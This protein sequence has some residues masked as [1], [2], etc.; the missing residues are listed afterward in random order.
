[1][2]VFKRNNNNNKSKEKSNARNTLC[3]MACKISVVFIFVVASCFWKQLIF[4]CFKIFFLCVFLGCF[5][6][7]MSKINF[8]KYYF[9][10]FPCESI[11]KSNRYYNIKHY[12]QWWWYIF[13]LGIT[14]FFC[15]IILCSKGPF[16][17]G[18]LS[19]QSQTK[20]ILSNSR[21]RLCDWNNQ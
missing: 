19:L 8:K 20:H 16:L 4:F 1:M 6:V 2:F 15:L 12:H 7:L 14:N 18:F 17:A 21:F 10:I 9:D 11:L 5:D 13:F 3:V